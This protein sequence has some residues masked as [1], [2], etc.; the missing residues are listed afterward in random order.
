MLKK[1]SEDH[2]LKLNKFEAEKLEVIKLPDFSPMP[3]VNMTEVFSA[4][5]VAPPKDIVAVKND[6]KSWQKGTKN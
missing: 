6:R 5:G 4:I 1:Q 3:P 2:R